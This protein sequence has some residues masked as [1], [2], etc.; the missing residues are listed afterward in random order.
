MIYTLEVS[1]A[2]ECP[3]GFVFHRIVRYPWQM[4]QDKVQRVLQEALA[5]WSA[6]TPLRFIEVTTETADISID[7]NR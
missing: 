7:F 3:S 5:V 1:T 2:I 6:V 4:S